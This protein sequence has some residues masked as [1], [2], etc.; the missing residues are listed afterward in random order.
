M[1]ETLEFAKDL[2]VDFFQ[3]NVLTPYPGTQLYNEAKEKGLI[4]HEEY[5]RYGQ[6]EVVMKLQHLSP[7]EVMQFEKNTF[8]RFFLQPKIIFRQLL[9]LRNLSQIIDLWRVLYVFL[10]EGFTT[11]KAKSK[12]LE[13]WLNFDTETHALKNIPIP[14]VPRLTYEVRQ[15]LIFN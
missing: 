3:V 14:E 11:H 10:I 8:R 15:E 7:E 13:S 1:E 12:N 9:R 5:E 4:L 6:N 2:D